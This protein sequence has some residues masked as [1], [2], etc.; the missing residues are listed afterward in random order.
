MQ[1]ITDSSLSKWPTQRI[2]AFGENNAN[3]YKSFCAIKMKGQLT[4]SSCM[5]HCLFLSISASWTFP[6]GIQNDS[7]PQ[8]IEEIRLAPNKTD[9]QHICI[10]VLSLSLFRPVRIPI[11]ALK[12]QN[13]AY[14]RLARKELPLP[15]F[16]GCRMYWQSLGNEI[17]LLDESKIRRGTSHIP[18]LLDWNPTFC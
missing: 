14:V 9:L 3:L 13:P 15:W 2:N 5:P 8:Y 12:P 1:V 4:L 7:D 6:K 18:L 10:L 11:T 16:C 17:S